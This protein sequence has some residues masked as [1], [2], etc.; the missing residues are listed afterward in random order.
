MKI[1]DVIA[2]KSVRAEFSNST[3]SGSMGYK[4]PAGQRFVFLLLGVDDGDV[5]LDPIK[6]LNDL[7][8]YPSEVTKSA[9]GGNDG[10]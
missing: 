5:K 2:A 8:W 7:G 10:R 1:G 6:A 3:A 9:E 4:A